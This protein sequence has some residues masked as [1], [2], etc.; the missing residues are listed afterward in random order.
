MI[1]TPI[2]KKSNPLRSLLMTLLALVGL[3]GGCFLICEIIFLLNNAGA[4]PGT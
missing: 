3:I 4:T 2:K 1:G